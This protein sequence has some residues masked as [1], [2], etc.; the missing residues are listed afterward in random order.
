MD[1][2]MYAHR[3][4]LAT[5]EGGAKAQREGQTSEESSTLDGPRQLK[6]LSLIL[7][8]VG[9]R[10]PIFCGYP[11]PLIMRNVRLVLLDTQEFLLDPFVVRGEFLLE[12]ARGSLLLGSRFVGGG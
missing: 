9:G 7:R 1:Q 3:P 5:D 10:L 6:R 8:V 12:T 11:E 2:D 4:R